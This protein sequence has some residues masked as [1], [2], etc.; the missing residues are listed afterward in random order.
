MTYFTKLRITNYLTKNFVFIEC[1]ICKKFCQNLLE[2]KLINMKK[3]QLILC[4]LVFAIVP[5]SFGVGCFMVKDKIIEYVGP[6]TN[7]TIAPIALLRVGA[8][9]I[10][11][12][13]INFLSFAIRQEVFVKIFLIVGAGCVLCG[14]FGPWTQNFP[15]VVVGTLSILL[16]AFNSLSLL[17]KD[18]K[19]IAAKSES[20]V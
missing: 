2:I 5:F 10:V 3:Y 19:K 8:F 18:P 1:I 15:F 12:G 4:L 17:M 11:V 14:N 20:S 16:G 13:V 9:F 7:E 6:I